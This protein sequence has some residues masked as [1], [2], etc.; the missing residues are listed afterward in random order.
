MVELETS[1]PS[2]PEQLAEWSLEL[3]TDGSKLT[4]TYDPHKTDTGINDLLQAIQQAGLFVKDI[5]TTKTSL[6]EI[7]VGLVKAK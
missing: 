5:N 7:F 3:S 6:E 2:I 1:L 4:Y